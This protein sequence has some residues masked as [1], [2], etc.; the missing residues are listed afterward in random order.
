MTFSCLTSG[1]QKGW[2]DGILVLFQLSGLLLPSSVESCSHFLW[3]ALCDRRQ[4][5]AIQQKDLHNLILLIY[6][7]YVTGP[8]ASCGSLRTVKVFVLTWERRSV[9]ISGSVFCLLQLCC[10]RSLKRNSYKFV[11]LC[12]S[13]VNLVSQDKALKQVGLHTIITSRLFLFSG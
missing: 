13:V 5:E 2:N 4:A 3:V 9:C 8:G 7:N 11:L 10:V 1:T 6:V 12:A